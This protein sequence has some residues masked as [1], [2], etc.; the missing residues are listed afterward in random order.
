M[1]PKLLRLRHTIALSLLIA[2]GGINGISI[3]ADGKPVTAISAADADGTDKITIAELET[4]IKNQRVV[5]LRTAYN[6]PYGTS[7]L[8]NS[9]EMTYYIA[10]FQQKNFWRVLRMTSDTRA[11]QT[12][13]EQM[14][15]TERMAAADIR[16]IKLEAERQA[17]EKQIAQKASRL[18]AL[19]NDAALRKQQEEKMAQ[20]Q[21]QNRQQVAALSSEQ[22]T[23]RTQLTTL[24][25]KIQALEGG[26]AESPALTEQT[27]AAEPVKKRKRKKKKVAE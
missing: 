21:D 4:L 13:R 17:T 1:T 6:G 16:R 2:A 5:E 11:E 24:E 10:S 18:S 22:Q 8:F 3:A 12:Y 9:E 23:A 7:L 25:N 14:A 19:Q 26:Q 27:A 15:E 20:Q